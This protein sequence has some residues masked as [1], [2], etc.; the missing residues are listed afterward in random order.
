MGPVSAL[1]T[2]SDAAFSFAHSQSGGA[3]LAPGRPLKTSDFPRVLKGRELRVALHV[4]IFSANS[5]AEVSW[6]QKQSFGSLLDVFPP[7]PCLGLP[8]NLVILDYF[9]TITSVFGKF[10]LIHDCHVS[11]CVRDHAR[12]LQDIGSHA[13]A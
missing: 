5:A 10:R 6:D 3:G 11:P 12:F 8:V 1:F 9:V 7:L 4:R 2:R 13:D